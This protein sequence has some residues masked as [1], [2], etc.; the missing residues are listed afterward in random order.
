MSYYGQM[1]TALS[2][3]GIHFHTAEIFFTQRHFF[4][5]YILLKERDLATTASLMDNGIEFQ[6]TTACTRKEE[7]NKKK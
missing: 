6:L 5:N 4:V 1:L 7:L 2:V 3:A